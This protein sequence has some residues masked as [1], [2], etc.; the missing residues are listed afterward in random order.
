VQTVHVMYT[1]CNITTFSCTRVKHRYE[2]NYLLW[3]CVRMARHDKC[4]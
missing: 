1:A 4:T 3:I 2:I